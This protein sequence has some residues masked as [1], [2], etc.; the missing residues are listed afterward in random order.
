MKSKFFY[1][2]SKRIIDVVASLIVLVLSLPLL[3]V[4]AFLI[5]LTM[6]RP[7]F[8]KQNRPGYKGREF[9]LIKFRTMRGGY[10]PKVC[11]SKD[12]ERITRLGSFLRK[13][14][15]DE[16]PEFYNVLKGDMSLVGP[17]PL[18]TQYLE[19]YTVEQ[20]RRHDVRPGITGWAQVNGRNDTSWED[21]FS[22]DVWYVDN[23]SMF[24]DVKILF[25]T[26]FKVLACV[27]IS[28]KGEATM[29]EF[30]RNNL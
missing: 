12:G 14:S 8:F 1:L 20:M 15:L 11:A 10:D 26:V 4:V 22:Q 13:T 17:R 19:R 21:R 27:G 18:L 3:S 6:G 7:I 23:C 29:K 30:S 9:G 24:L 25:M 2:F 16:F 28:Q 5:L